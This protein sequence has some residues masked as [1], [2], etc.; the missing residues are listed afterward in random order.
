MKYLAQ[1]AAREIL[2]SPSDFIEGYGIVGD[3]GI[4]TEVVDTDEE[5]L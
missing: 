2:D 5:I 4:K 1:L 3:M